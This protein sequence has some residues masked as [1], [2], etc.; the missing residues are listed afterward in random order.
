[1]PINTYLFI[2]SIQIGVSLH[3]VLFQG[4]TFCFLDYLP[5]GWIDFEIYVPPT[6]VYLPLTKNCALAGNQNAA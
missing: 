2:L 5:T 3:L 6:Y 1:M 4:W